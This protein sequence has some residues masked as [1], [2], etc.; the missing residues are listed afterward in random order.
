MGFRPDPSSYIYEILKN[1][2]LKEELNIEIIFSKK[3]SSTRSIKEKLLLNLPFDFVNNLRLKK[4]SIKLFKFNRAKRNMLLIGGCKE[5]LEL[6]KSK[7]FKKQYNFKFQ[8]V[9]KKNSS[10]KIDQVL[11]NILNKALFNESTLLYRMDNIAMHINSAI[12]TFNSNI[13]KVDKYIKKF[14]LVVSSTLIYPDDN[15]FAH[16]A[17]KCQKPLLVWQ[18]GEKGAFGFDIL[19]QYQELY[20][21]TDYLSY[22]EFIKEMYIPWKGKNFLKE[23]ISVGSID[24]RPKY[25]IKKKILLFMPQANGS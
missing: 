9:F 5:W 20:F 11:I 23:V 6:F 10:E 16:R 12:A 15:F 24:K 13:Q 25:Q 18:H 8:F 17:N 4:N 14:D 7:F 2:P 21:A 19:A 22:S 1:S 3:F